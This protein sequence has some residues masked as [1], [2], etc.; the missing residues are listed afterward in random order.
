MI[1]LLLGAFSANIAC[2]AEPN[3]ENL[4]ILTEVITE[5]EKFIPD[6]WELPITKIGWPLASRLRSAV[7]MTDRL[8]ALK[9]HSIRLFAGAYTASAQ[10]PYYDSEDG[11]MCVLSTQ[12][13]KPVSVCRVV[14]TTSALDRLTV[15][16]DDMFIPPAPTPPITSAEESEVPF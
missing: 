12:P 4:E 8:E 9:E 2:D 14:L 3:R 11:H 10:I 6:P 16:V 15:Q 7:D 5:I 1:D 13:F